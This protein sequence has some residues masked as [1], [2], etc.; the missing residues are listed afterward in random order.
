VTTQQFYTRF[1][2]L[3]LRAEMRV[4][5]YKQLAAYMDHMRISADID[6]AALARELEEC[7]HDVRQGLASDPAVRSL[8][9]L[10]E[11]IDILRRLFDLELTPDEYLAFA[12]K[13]RSTSLQKRWRTAFRD[14]GFDAAH[15]D[16]A[17]DIEGYIPAA[18]RF[19]TAARKRNHVMVDRALAK[20]DE[21]KATTAV[22]IAG[23]FHTPHLTQFLSE[24]GVNVVVVAP[25]VTE[26]TDK[27]RY[28]DFLKYDAEF[29]FSDDSNTDANLDTATYSQR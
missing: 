6:S 17:K 24:A 13:L 1:A 21:L 12:T 25:Q 16:M 27:Q 5:D 15:A 9:N 7:V 11:E 29:L 23:G 18:A 19:Y 8:V 10:A 26:S 28:H 14:H 3:M 20:M 2:Q 4:A 22:L